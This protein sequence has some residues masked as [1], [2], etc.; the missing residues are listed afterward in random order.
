MALSAERATVVRTIF[1]TIVA[2]AS[3]ALAVVVTIGQKDAGA[4]CGGRRYQT[5]AAPGGASPY[6]ELTADGVSGPFLLDT[7]AT[8][9]SLSAAAFDSTAGPVRKAAIS[10]PD[11]KEHDF[12]LARYDDLP[13]QTPKGQLG[14]IGTNILSR[15]V[16]QLSGS[17]AF[18]GPASCQ[19]EALSARGLVPIAQNGFFSSDP[20]QI[21]GGLP[22]VPV[23]FLRLGEARAWAQIDTGYDDVVYPHSVDI[24]EALYDSLIKSGVKLERFADIVVWTCDGR[25]KR[26]VY[27]VKGRPLVIENERGTSIVQTE[28]F[29][30]TVKPSNACGGIAAFDTPAA[31]LGASFL[32]LFGTTVFDP[33]SGTVWLEGDAGRRSAP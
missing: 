2:G 15:L 1:L 5:I 16:L 22:N 13:L 30:L 29:H 20:A 33:K 12:D 11:L 8:R 3:I 7:G 25:E 28:T 6:I 26:P 23:V 31:Q 10:L 21:K 19:P 24:N 17:A 32:R 9:S 4:L 18:L 14:V 27:V